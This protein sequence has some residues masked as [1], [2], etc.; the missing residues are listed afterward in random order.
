MSIGVA[1]TLT[2][3]CQ[4]ENRPGMLG[5]L[6]TIIGECGGDIGAIDLVR[7]ESAFL[8][9]DLTVRVQGEQHGEDLIREIKQAPGID[10]IGVSDRVFL[11]H[12]GGKLAVQSRVPLKTR[13]DLSLAYTPGVAR[14]CQAIADD[15]EQAYTLTMKQNT[16]AV[17]SDGS[18]ILG[19][20]NL[21]PEAALPVMEGKAILFKELANVDAFPICLRSQDPETIVATVEQIAPVFGGINLEDIAAPKC[22][23]V[24]GRLHEQ[25]DIPVMHDDQHGTAIVALAAL[26][27]ALKLVGK[28]LSDVRVVVNGMGAAGT[29]IARSLIEAGVGEITACGR[30][31][32]LW[33]GDD[34]SLPP[35]QRIIATLTNQE[36]R[37]GKLTDALAGADVFI[38]VSAANILTPAMV[39][40]MTADPIIFALANPIPEGDPEVLRNYARVVATGRS[41]QPN[42][43]NNVLSFPGIFRG[44]LDVHARSMTAGMRLAAAEALASVIPAEEVNEEYIIPSVFNR[45][46]V[47]AIAA[48]VAQAALNDKV[49][50]HN[51]LP[52]TPL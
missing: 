39:E 29:A 47:P 23:I 1:Y 18:A 32:I 37:T 28:R 14:V 15:V 42:Q 12:L 48:A 26:R 6:T 41:D 2:I 50:R 51:H 22:F 30:H 9:R 35:M 46:V 36:G 4:I 44:A 33:R 43:I 21:G 25:L 7:A 27:N 52:T 11:T 5:K 40:S 16:V 38:G 19:L 3:R 8:V 24:E 34:A 20:G 49:A 31:G 17:V 10:V 45:A 13:D